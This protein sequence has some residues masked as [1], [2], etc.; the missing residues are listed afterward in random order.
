MQIPCLPLIL[1]R[2]TNAVLNH[3]KNYR[4]LD[5]TMRMFTQSWATTA[6]GFGGIGG[7]AITEAYTVI[8]EDYCT[9]WY[10]VFFG[11][12][13]AY[14]IQNPNEKFFEDIRKEQMESVSKHNKYLRKEIK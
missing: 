8:V 12:G 1:E 13:L 9:G 5:A 10:S 11:D 2:H 6:L 3:D 4:N 7:C 14:T